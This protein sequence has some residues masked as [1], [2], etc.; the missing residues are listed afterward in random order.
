MPEVRVETDEGVAR[1]VLDAPARRNALTVAMA[2][3]LVAACEEIDADPGVGAVVVCGADGQFCAGAD[4]DTLLGTGSD[5]AAPD[6]YDAV[7]W[8]YRAFVRV[9]ELEPPTI[10]AVRGAAVGA[11]VN[12]ML[13]TDLRVV[14]HDAR[15]VS[16]FSKLGIHPGGGHFTLALRA[17]GRESAAAVG[18]FGEELSG[19]RAAELGM[20]WEALDS[21][22]VEARALELARRAAADPELARRTARSMRLQVGPPGVS[23]PVALEAERA[24]Q[25]WSLR[26]AA[27]RRG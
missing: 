26:R 23:W 14:A 4:R 21:E 18:L 5:P 11:G 9:G 16:G 25:M 13:A 22:E 24:A 3:E 17:A 8:I 1:L 19:A 2:Q 7:G 12:L 15:I 20:A 6:A 10:A 27:G